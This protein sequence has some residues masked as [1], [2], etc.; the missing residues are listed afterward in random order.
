MKKL[1]L[2]TLMTFG[3]IVSL[4]AATPE[5]QAKLNELNS[6]VHL[7]AAQTPKAEAIITNFMSRV[8]ELK[9]KVSG[10]QL[11]KAKQIEAK[12]FQ[13]KLMSI[14]TDAQKKLYLA[15]FSGR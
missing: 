7:D 15:H 4:L 8:T 12:A 1:V 6:V 2:T 5:V 3:I 9:A 11:K 14:M 10:D 13:D